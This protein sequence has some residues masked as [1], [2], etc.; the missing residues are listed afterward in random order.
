VS[1]LIFCLS[2]SIAL[3]KVTGLIVSSLSPVVVVQVRSEHDY[4]LLFPQAQFLRHRIFVDTIVDCQRRL[5]PPVVM[6]KKIM[7]VCEKY[8]VLKFS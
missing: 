2:G 5:P 1:C 8:A 4:Y 7:V 3:S 6:L